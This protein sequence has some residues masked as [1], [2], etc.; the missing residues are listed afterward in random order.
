MSC[1]INVCDRL[2]EKLLDWA[3]EVARAKPSGTDAN[4]IAEDFVV[5][6]RLLSFFF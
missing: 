3:K 1:V 5:S 2:Q 4:L 6:V